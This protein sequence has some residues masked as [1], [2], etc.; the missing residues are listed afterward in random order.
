MMNALEKIEIQKASISNI[1]DLQK[2]SRDTF[3]ETFVT[4]TSEENMRLYLENNF[5]KE[6]LL[7][8]LENSYSEFYFALVENNL[9]G[10]LKINF[11]EAQT[12]LNDDNALEVER[13]YVR[14]NYHGKGVG[15]Q[16]LDYAI[17]VAKQKNM[18]TVWL[19]VWENN[20][21]AINFYK[22]NGFVT[23]DTHVFMLGEEAQTDYMMRLDLI[24]KE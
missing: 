18:Q 23:F 10:Y 22:K 6:K 13:I 20:Q 14:N 11:S 1:D 9:A 19:G 17:Q 5:S 21:R 24:T 3:Y 8:E 7:K 12:D 4:S 16:L 15:R 2:I